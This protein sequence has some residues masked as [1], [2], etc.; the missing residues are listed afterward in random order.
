MNS[1]RLSIHAFL[2]MIS[3]FCALGKAQAQ[4]A[5]NSGPIAIS[6]H[7]VGKGTIHESNHAIPGYFVMA[8]ITN[9]QDTA[10]K[11][12]IM[13]CSWASQNWITSNDSIY[14]REPGCDIN[15]LADIHLRPHQS[16]HFYGALTS[17]GKK[18][19][20]KKVKLGF[21]YITNAADE[22]FTSAERPKVEKPTIYWSNEVEVKDNLFE[23]EVD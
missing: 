22:W 6:L 20:S 16:V 9:Q 19:F 4:N 5:G 8:T 21:R 12:F 11:F 13:S 1:I 10:I 23:Y 7:V 3:F 15:V 17:S 2:L 18:P 14:F